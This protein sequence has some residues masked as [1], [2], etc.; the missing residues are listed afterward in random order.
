[1][2]CGG[3]GGTK[4]LDGGGNVDVGVG[5]WPFGGGGGGGDDL[6]GGGGLV[7][8]MSLESLGTAAR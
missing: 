3:G 4:R 5:G 2:A 8:R 6:P 1:M 7:T